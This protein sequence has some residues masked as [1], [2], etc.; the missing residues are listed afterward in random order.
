MK[1][2][3]DTA[4]VD[5]I[6]RA[7]E[8]G[9]ICGVTTNPSLIAR[10]G[11]D[12]IEVIKEISQIVDG[13]ISAE[14]VSLKAD[15]M[16]A[17]ACDL[18]EKIGS[19]N[20]VIKIPMCAE[21][22][23][24]TKQLTALGIKTNVTL[25]FSTA[26]ALLAARAGATYVSPF[27]GRLDDIGD[28]GISLVED[29][30][31]IFRYYDIK[32]EI[33][34]LAKDLPQTGRISYGSKEM[35]PFRDRVDN[36]VKMLL[37]YD[38]RARKADVKFYTALEK[39]RKVIMNI[40]GQDYVFSDKN[41]SPENIERDLPKYHHKIDE[42]NIKIIDDIEA[43]YKRRQGNLVLQLAKFIKPEYYER[44]KGKKYKVNDNKLKRSLA[45]SKRNVEYRLDKFLK[46]FGRDLEELY[47]R[48]FSHRL[49]DIEKE[50]ERERAKETG[51]SQNEKKEE[52][53][54]D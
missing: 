35:E 22:L 17:E 16:V 46:A 10:E 26:Q 19:K 18:Y 39:K 23:K 11:R 29:I 33:I 40:C 6:R 9:V 27:V 48:D 51:E 37:D 54:K 3:I 45:I 1:I 43:D 52:V 38:G 20:T 13:P 2:F 32:T 7:N 25:I 21:G 44:K 24:A 36:I 53:V 8:L 30:A 4:N 50:I 15:E 34:S 49:Q 31:A 47:E 5:E 42:S 28:N 41:I 14:V 12:F